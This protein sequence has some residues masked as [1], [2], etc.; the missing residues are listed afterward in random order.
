MTVW[1]KMPAPALLS[2]DQ[3]LDQY[4]IKACLSCTQNSQV[5]LVDDLRLH[6]PLV[7]KIYA[8]DFDHDATKQF[9]LQAALMLELNSSSH[10]VGFMHL[11]EYTATDKHANKQVRPYI[12]MPYYPQTLQDLLSLYPQSMGFAS[13]ISIVTNVLKALVDVHQKGIVHCDI[14]PQNIY[15]DEANQAFLADFDNAVVLPESGLY[16]KFL[17]YNSVSRKMRLSQGFASPE[18]LRCVHADTGISD[19]DLTCDL[20]SVGLLWCRLLSGNSQQVSVQP[21]TNSA[22]KAKDDIEQSIALFSKTAPLWATTLITALLKEAPEQRPQSAMIVLQ[23]IEQNTQ[24]VEANPTLAADALTDFSLIDRIKTDIS[25]SLLTKGVVDTILFE[26]LL[27]SYVQAGDKSEQARSEYLDARKNALVSLIDNCRDELIN[28]KG[29]SSWFAW[30]NYVQTL[31]SDALT[32]D[33]LVKKIKVNHDKF[34]QIVQVGRASR[35]DNPALAQHIAESIFEVKDT[36]I[37]KKNNVLLPTIVIVCV[38]ILLFSDVLPTLN[39]SQVTDEITIKPTVAEASNEGNLTL[40]SDENRQ[41]T[42][43]TNV[44]KEQKRLIKEAFTENKLPVSA[45]AGNYVLRGGNDNAKSNNPI[46]IPWV[47]IK[48]L[49]NIRIF[50]TEISNEIY[51]LCVKEGGCRGATRFTT[52]TKSSAHLALHPRI[53]VSWHDI[54]T[55]FIPWLNQKLSRKFALPNFV[56]WQTFTRHTDIFSNTNLYTKNQVLN[57]HCRDC[58]DGASMHYARQS[59]GDT[60]PVFSLQA[61][62]DG[63]YHVF[64]NVQE[65]LSDCWQAPNNTTKNSQRC[66]QAMVAGGSWMSL[67]ADIKNQAVTQLLKTARSTTTGFRLIEQL[68]GK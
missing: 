12:V 20:Y 31:S 22:N 9:D 42:D 21:L 56:Q 62:R 3:K 14:K 24:E 37:F 26:R 18:L 1:R 7:L 53:N 16:K 23:E 28:N 10:I 52:N 41:T 13:T 38:F 48:E 2:I 44:K 57:L 64:G 67:E 46:K 55:Q 36:S 58:M 27:L 63:L 40:N 45:L 17:S 50:T 25:A 61:N 8:G 34:A 35:I 39:N 15:F 54:N 32:R 29:L 66:D 68:D 43:K 59:G 19:L 49:P 4:T 5:Y 30:I 11:G 51:Q 47:K 65:W 60:M 6:K 33:K